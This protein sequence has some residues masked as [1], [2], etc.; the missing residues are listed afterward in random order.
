[1]SEPTRYQQNPLRN[2]VV[3]AL[4]GGGLGLG[5]CELFLSVPH[6]EAGIAVVAGAVLCGTLGYF[7]GESFVT[8]LREHVGW[9]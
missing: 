2:I 8:W 4:V 5:V 3:G 1:M 7:L 9:F 6:L